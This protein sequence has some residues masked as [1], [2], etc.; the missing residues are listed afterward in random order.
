VG[1]LRQCHRSRPGTGQLEQQL[2]VTKTEGTILQASA[3]QIWV[4]LQTGSSSPNIYLPDRSQP[5]RVGRIDPRTGAFT[6]KDLKIGSSGGYDSFAAGP[7]MAWVGDF[8]SSTVTAIGHAAT[9]GDRR[10]RNR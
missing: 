2:S 3:S 1:R 8:A 4:L 9:A 10:V 5:G 6:G 7:T